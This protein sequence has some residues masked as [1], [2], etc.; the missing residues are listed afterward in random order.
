[1]RRWSALQ[2][3]K[4]L[5]VILLLFLN[6][7]LFYRLLPLLGVVAGFLLRVLLPFAVAAAIAYLLHPLVRR[8]RAIGL[9]CTV[10]ILMIYAA[11]FSA[12]AL[13]VYKGL[14]VLMHELQGLSRHFTEYEHM[15]QTKV[16]HLY[17]AT[18]EAVHDHVN[19]VLLRFQHTLSAVIERF[20]DWLSMVV[21]SFFT[22]MIIPFLSFYFLKDAGPIL[23]GI[24]HLV[25]LRWQTQVSTLGKELDRS[26]G[27][28]VR[29]QLTVC[30][31]LAVMGTLGLWLL[32]IPYPLV[33]GFFI[34]L[35]DLIP[36]FGPFIGAAPAVLVA[37]TQSLPQAAGVVV[38]I[39][40]IQFLEGN[41]VEPLI[42]GR[43]VNIHPLYIMLSL[44]I[45]GEMAGIVGMLLA[46][47]SFIVIRTCFQEYS[48]RHERLTTKDRLNYNNG[49]ITKK[50]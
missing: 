28:Y 18:P 50:R 46:V 27:N 49:R 42:I 16:D 43:S 29:G 32:H 44:G 12:C 6:G 20:V 36:Y 7:Y 21:R 35:T 33:F 8:L 41:V 3:M 11:F 9:P 10:A 39:I 34:G 17:G 23:K 1:M 19:R 5:T 30:G 45:G 26:I 24:L 31:I 40:M 14:P 48:K 15:Y 2:W 47:P 22:L 38:M 13:L 4:G 37:A 25:P